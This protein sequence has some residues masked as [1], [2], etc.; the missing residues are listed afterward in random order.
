MIIER[1]TGIGRRRTE[2]R[3]VKRINAGTSEGGEKA[4]QRLVGKS[5]PPP[6]PPPNPRE[7][8]WKK[9]KGK[10]KQGQQLTPHGEPDVGSP[11]PND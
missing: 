6:H 4:D 8:L 9:A 5:Q 1:G 11:T 3:P 7:T 10:P 2:T